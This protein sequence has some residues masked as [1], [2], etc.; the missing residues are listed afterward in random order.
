MTVINRP[1]NAALA[2]TTLT[3]LI[4]TSQYIN[5]AVIVMISYTNFFSTKQNA[6]EN[7]TGNYFIGP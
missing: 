2:L 3:F 5:T 4:F 7:K 6:A 1:K